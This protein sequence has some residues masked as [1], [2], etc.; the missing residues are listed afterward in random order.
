M[1]ELPKNFCIAP[2]TQITTH[3]NGSFSP[4][5]YLGG[6]V[7]SQQYPTITERFQGQD[8]ENLRLQFLS[9]QQSPVCERCWHEERNNKKSLRLRLYDPVNQTSDYSVIN[10][11]LVI[12]DLAQ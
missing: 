12:E 1:H 7:W 6:T 4:C 5:P 11:S 2:F 10:N 9:N 8:L 3:P